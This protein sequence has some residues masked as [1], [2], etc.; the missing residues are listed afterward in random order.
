MN[1][2]ERA[3]QAMATPPSIKGRIFGVAI[4]DVNKL[5]AAGEISPADLSRWLRAE[6]VALL[7]Q[8]I[9]A[10]S[11]YDIQSYARI[12]VLL[13][14]VEGYGSNDYLRERGAKS[15]ARLLEAGLYNQM[16]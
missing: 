4:E 16:E 3:G 1:S 12:L 15:A 2:W 7:G 8:T 11:W 13:R 9:A 5:L 6:D 10:A 14:D